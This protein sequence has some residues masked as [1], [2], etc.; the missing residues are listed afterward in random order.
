MMISATRGYL[1]DMTAHSVYGRYLL[2]TIDMAD[3]LSKWN[4]KLNQT[5][6]VDSDQ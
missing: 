2:P 3:L 4:E 5:E 1:A 6:Q